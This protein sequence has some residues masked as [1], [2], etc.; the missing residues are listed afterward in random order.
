ML[1][2][3]LLQNTAFVLLYELTRKKVRVFYF[4]GAEQH[5]HVGLCITYLETS[6]DD[7]HCLTT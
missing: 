6:H 5:Q 3:L 7:T 4:C 2:A 1:T